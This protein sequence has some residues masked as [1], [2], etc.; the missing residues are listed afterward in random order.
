MK[1]VILAGSPRKAS[2]TKRVALHLENVL[3]QR[4]YDTDLI[5]LAD[6]NLPPVEAVWNTPADAPT[7]FRALAER[8]EAADAYLLVTP[9]Y[10]GSYSPAMKNLL[11]HFTKRT[12]MPF[13]LVTASPGALGGM[14]AAQQLLLLVPALFGIA[15]PQFLLVPGVDKK[16]NE[17][18][19]LTD[20]SFEKNISVFLEEFCW[21]CGR[22]V[23]QPVLQ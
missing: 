1:I 15:C 2:L 12:R 3:K 22:I 14:R 11:D 9:E 16:F 7:L 8:M 4:E 21:L 23:N 5:N 18:G 13:G 20:P 19:Q 17:A 6:W 10:N